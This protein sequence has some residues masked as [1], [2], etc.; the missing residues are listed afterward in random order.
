MSSDK[1]KQDSEQSLTS[2]DSSELDSFIDHLWLEDG[3]AKNT[4]SSYRL[5]LSA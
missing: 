1:A 3:L 4:L 2:A 5:D